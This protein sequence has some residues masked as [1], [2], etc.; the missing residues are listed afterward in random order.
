MTEFSGIKNVLT[1]FR[2]NN[3]KGLEKG[4]KP[5]S[6]I[7]HRSSDDDLCFQKCQVRATISRTFVFWKSRF[8]PQ[9]LTI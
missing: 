5:E 4:V 1:I 9:F 3:S 6:D 8:F 2:R 7:L